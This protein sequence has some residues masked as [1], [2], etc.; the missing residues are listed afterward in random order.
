MTEEKAKV[1]AP[2]LSGGY[3]VN[4]EPL[5]VASL[6]GGP[7]LVDFWDYT[8]VNC[9]HTLPY[10]IEWQR[11]VAGDPEWRRIV[12]PRRRASGTKEKRW[13]S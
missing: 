3:W 6:R 1:H 5:T 13:T 2:E 10:V 7:V 12:P 9:I 11:R 4:G 8:C